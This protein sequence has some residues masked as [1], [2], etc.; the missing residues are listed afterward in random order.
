[1][2]ESRP[3]GE[4]RGRQLSRPEGEP[5]GRQLSKEAACR[6]EAIEVRGRRRELVRKGPDH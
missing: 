4:P 3:E 1:M 2:L 5:R 6:V